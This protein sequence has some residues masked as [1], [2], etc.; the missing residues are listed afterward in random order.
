M[1]SAFEL[2][3]RALSTGVTVSKGNP[4]VSCGKGEG[5]VELLRTASVD[6]SGVSLVKAVFPHSQRL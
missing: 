3:S 1:V 4:S 5:A 6:C 2:L